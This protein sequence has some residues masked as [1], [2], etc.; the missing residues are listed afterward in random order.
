MRCLQDPVMGQQ[1]SDDFSC[2]KE[3]LSLQISEDCLYLNIYIPGMAERNRKLPVMVWLHGGGLAVG[4]ASTYD[5]SALAAFEEVVVVVLQYR[6]GIPGFLSTG[7]ESAPG[8]WGFL[9]QVAALQW[10][11][12]NI[13]H[14]GGDPGS[15]TIFGESAGGQSVSFLIMSPLAK[16]LFHKA[17]SQSG[18]QPIDSLATQPVIPA[19]ETAALA[20]CDPS[21]TT[22]ET[23]HCL[24]EKTEEQILETTLK[25]GFLTLDI[26]GKETAIFMPVGA[27]G[28]FLPKNLQQLLTA[29]EINGVPYM[30]GV[31]NQEFG[32]LLPTML[33]FPDFAKGLSRETIT[34]IL[35][36]LEPLTN[37]PP[38]YVDILVDEYLREAEKPSQLRD[39]FLDLL[40]DVTCVVPSVQMARY[41]RDAGHPV[42]FYE[43]QHRPSSHAGLKPDYVQSDHGDE[44]GFIF[45]KP[46]L[47]GN[48]TE[49]EKHLSR[50]VMR[51]WAN[52]ARTGDP[53]GDGLVTWPAY[54][55][56]EQYLEMGLKQKPAQKLR[57]THVMFWTEI[58]PQKT[59]GRK[60]EHS[61][62]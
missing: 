48:A 37:V 49:E 20:G 26:N 34:Y 61:E 10:V 29:K 46:F 30:I 17:I 51:Y 60:K 36:H 56:N 55:L 43:F 22:T 42:Y 28:V 24:R 39:R 18:V 62:L 53:N 27:D 59:A 7:D 57:D 21:A 8:N 47:A 2:R 35:Q 45:G 58:L 41:Y 19:K 32:W 23:L 14:F 4:A 25:L 6:L 13:A 40:G 5:G 11:Q 3:K 31:N 1:L 33:Q 38:E 15:V 50:K 44:I 52:F 9:D 54:D 12:E 16:G